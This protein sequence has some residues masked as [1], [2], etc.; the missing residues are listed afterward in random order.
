MKKRLIALLSAFWLLLPL[1]AFAGYAGE[2]TGDSVNVRSG[3]DVNFEVLTKKD[4]G[5]MV[6]VR[7]QKGEWLK[8]QA[9][10]DAQAYVHADYLKPTSGDQ[11]AITGNRVN[12][13]ANAG[14]E[15]NVIGQ[16][17]DGDMVQVIERK[18]AWVRIRPPEKLNAWISAGFV[19]EQGPEVL[20]DDQQQ[21]GRTAMNML[22]S[23]RQLEQDDPNNTELLKQEY[24][25]L[26]EMFSETRA[27][28][29]AANRLEQLEQLEQAKSE[30]IAEQ[31]ESASRTILA[32]EPVATGKLAETGRFFSRPGTHRLI[33]DGR[34]AYYLKSDTINL[35]DYVYHDVAVWG[36]LDRGQSRIPV[37]VVERVETL[38]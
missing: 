34:A 37:I 35:N 15:Y 1:A 25:N 5:D 16:L 32:G 24:Q 19:K 11:G 8:I 30:S 14:T 27:G 12:V 36:R 13:R 33:V 3:P 38:N 7:E 23:I 21:T 18:G 4:R 10:W 9:P 26:A 28:K 22:D 2:V 17:D 20:Y 31:D 29:L 6:L